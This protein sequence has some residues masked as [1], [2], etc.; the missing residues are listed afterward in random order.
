MRQV[1]KIL[2]LIFFTIYLSSTGYSQIGLDGQP[3]SLRVNINKISLEKGNSLLNNFVQ[4]ASK[5]DRFTYING[6]D[7][8]TEVFDKLYRYVNKFIDSFIRYSKKEIIWEIDIKKRENVRPIY[9]KINTLKQKSTENRDSSEFKEIKKQVSLYELS[10]EKVWLALQFNDLII[11]R[12]PTYNSLNSSF[13]IPQKIADSISD[14][15]EK[16]WAY[17]Y[18]AEFAASHKYN[19]PSISYFYQAFEYIYNSKKDSLN[20]YSTLG[21]IFE[22]VADLFPGHESGIVHGINKQSNYLIAASEYYSLVKNVDRANKCYIKFLSNYSFLSYQLLEYGKDTVTRKRVAANALEELW[23]WYLG[24]Y[25]N[26]KKSD[27]YFFKSFY[28]IGTILNASDKIS[29]A[30]NFFLSALYFAPEI[31]NIDQFIS[32]LGNISLTYAELGKRK[33]AFK[34]SNFQFILANK[35]NDRVAYANALLSKSKLY[36]ILKQYKLALKYANKVSSD[37]FTFNS[38]YEFAALSYIG[39]EGYWLKFNALHFLKFDSVW[40]YKDYYSRVHEGHLVGF[41]RL[42]QSEADAISGWLGRVKAKQIEEEKKNTREQIE[43][44]KQQEVI[45]KRNI[46]ISA[47]GILLLLIIILVGIKYYKL[48][49]KTRDSILKLKDSELGAK[50]IE[51]QQLD[52]L[53]RNKIHNLQND[54]HILPNLLNDG[55]VDL[56]KAFINEWGTYQAYYFENW[57]NKNVTLEDEI[58]L[59]EQYRVVKILTGQE[60][61]IIKNISDNIEVNKTKYLQ[62]V[63]DTLLDNSVRRGFSKKSGICTFTI[64]IEECKGG[65]LCSILD[66][67]T[68]PED[69]DSYLRRSDSGLNILKARIKGVYDLSGIDMPQDFFIVEAL[70]NSSGTIVKFIIPYEKIV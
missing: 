44:K 26:N 18:I 54:Y 32:I 15:Y 67:G 8:I 21:W 24:V 39:E 17:I 1:K 14:L 68:P 16:G 69:P 4:I 49:I 30:N 65:L 5:N 7:T 11:P 46:W 45:N 40:I 23:N 48:K 37:P 9:N 42:L 61:R 43:L 41:T 56:A 6:N 29:E 70:A 53:A 64:N 55:K 31:E 19:E 10:K 36:F 51:L 57:N 60:I 34:Y 63:F 52:E 35:A 20:K 47:I 12:Q 27:G 38:I 59:L 33:L 28:S 22:Q 62:S 58:L 3:M 13:I 50:R 66:N 25:Q 2:L